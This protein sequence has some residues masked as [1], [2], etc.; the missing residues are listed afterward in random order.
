MTEKNLMQV[1]VWSD[2]RCP[3]CY[4]GKKKFE[5]ALSKFPNRDDVQVVWRSFELD[6]RM[7]TQTGTSAYDY[8]AKVKGITR[9]QAIEMHAHVERVGRSVGITFNFEN[10][11][12]ANSFN[13]H[14]L[15]QMAKV[16][17]LADKAEEELFAAHFVEGL[18]IDDKEV[19][20]HLAG[21]VGLDPGAAGRMLASDDYAAEVKAD[22]A[23]ARSIGIRGVPFFIM[24]DALAVSGAQDPELFLQALG[25]AFAEYKTGVKLS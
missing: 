10:L 9:D 18:N 20:L 12:V 7:V 22:Q 14:R 25:K 23:A 1:H 4:I 6:P 24:N 19:L 13:A 2:V 17:R 3:F 21:R 15:I 8:L 16:A 11:K 5:H